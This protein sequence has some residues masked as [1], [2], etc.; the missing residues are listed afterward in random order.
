MTRRSFVL[1]TIYLIKLGFDLIQITCQDSILDVSL[2]ENSVVGEPEV[3]CGLDGIEID[4]ITTYA[5]FGRLYVQVSKSITL[6]AF[7]FIKYSVII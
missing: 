2:I 5:F 1:W 6:L 7:N 3:E 4:V